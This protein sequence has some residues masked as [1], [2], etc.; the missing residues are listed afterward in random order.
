MGFPLK[1]HVKVVDNRLVLETHQF[2]ISIFKYYVASGY[3]L[4]VLE[5]V[6]ILKFCHNLDH[7]RMADGSQSDKSELH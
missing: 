5:G 1:L 3:I 2:K 6:F 7:G 4:C